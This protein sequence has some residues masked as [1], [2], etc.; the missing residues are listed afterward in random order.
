MLVYRLKNREVHGTSGF[1][2]CEFW[3]CYLCSNTYDTKSKA[4]FF[5]STPSISAFA[6]MDKIGTDFYKVFFYNYFMVYSYVL[7]HFLVFK[8][9]S[10]MDKM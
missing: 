6:V 1:Y 10:L 3:P 7:E 4:L 5:T 2:T 9:T 8:N